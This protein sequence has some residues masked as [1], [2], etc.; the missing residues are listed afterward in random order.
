MSPKQNRL[1]VYR[2]AATSKSVSGVV[3]SGDERLGRLRASFEESPEPEQVL[4]AEVPPSAGVA[5]LP[6]AGML[7]GA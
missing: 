6:S 5:V 4:E 3:K 1:R 2:R 7:A